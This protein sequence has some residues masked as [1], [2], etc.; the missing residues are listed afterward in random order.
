LSLTERIVDARQSG[1]AELLERLGEFLDAVLSDYQYALEIRN[2]KWLNRAHFESIASRD[3]VPVLLQGYWMPPVAEVY[4]DWRDP[5]Q[6]CDTVIIR[7]H[8]PDRE[9][10]EERTGKR[11]DTLVVRRDEEL[12]EIVGVVRDLLDADVDVYLAI[13]NHYEGCAPTTIVRVRELLGS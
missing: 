12:R 11:W 7:L 8:G 4:R 3:L 2:P 13:N 10:M 5:I 9:G 1:Q 6:R